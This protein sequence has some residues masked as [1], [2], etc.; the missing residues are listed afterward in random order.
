MSS[1]NRVLTREDLQREDQELRCRAALKIVDVPEE[2]VWKLSGPILFQMAHLCCVIDEPMH[3]RDALRWINDHKGE[4]I[5]HAH[6]VMREKNVENG[7]A[8]AGTDGESDVSP[9][10]PERKR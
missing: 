8:G 1:K 9:L 10:V 4:I 5:A 7:S 2:I 6:K 3:W